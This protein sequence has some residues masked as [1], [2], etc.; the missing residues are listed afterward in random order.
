MG[1]AGVRLYASGQPGGARAYRLLYQARLALD[2]AARLK[3]V[4]KMYRLRF[5]DDAPAR[6]SVDQL[7]S[8]QRDNHE[9]GRLRR[10]PTVDVTAPS[11]PF[12]AAC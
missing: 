9:P 4:R 6:R 12:S 1:E 7:P 8:L 3:V 5:K 11:D 10:P 2:D